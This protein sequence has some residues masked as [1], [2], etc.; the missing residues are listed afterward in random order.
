MKTPYSRDAMTARLTA[1][2]AE[3]AKIAPKVEALQ[4]EYADHEA[5]ARKAREKVIAAKGP[6][7]EL[8]NEIAHLH[9][10]LGARSLTLEPGKYEA[11]AGA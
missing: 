9:R 4:K 10:A 2:K 5:K 8:D 11:K 3:R 1:A 7:S 6:L